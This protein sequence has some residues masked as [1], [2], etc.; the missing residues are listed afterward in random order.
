MWQPHPPF[1]PTQ[2]TS[3]SHWSTPQQVP[4]TKSL[5]PYTADLDCRKNTFFLPSQ[6]TQTNQH[7]F[8]VNTRNTFKVKTQ[9]TSQHKG[10]KERHPHMLCTSRTELTGAVWADSKDEIRL[11]PCLQHLASNRPLQRG[12][13]ALVNQLGRAPNHFPL[14]MPHPPSV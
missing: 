5:A 3:A 13:A 8:I 4:H 6:N 14:D 12:D 10:L 2:T 1:P 11:C 7:Y 9:H